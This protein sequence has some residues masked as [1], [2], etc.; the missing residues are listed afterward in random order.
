M[1]DGQRDDERVEPQDP[2]EETVCQPDEQAEADA[3]ED[4]ES[5]PL[6]GVVRDA[7]D[8]GCPPRNI[9]PG[10]ERSIPACMITSIWPSAATARTVM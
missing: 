3:G 2:D 1:P 5:E 9:T 7:Q 4:A 6:V 10:I 8:R